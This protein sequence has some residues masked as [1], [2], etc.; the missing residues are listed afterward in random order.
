MTL[1]PQK[2]RK[3]PDEMESGSMNGA[4]RIA[5]LRLFSVCLNQFCE[6]ILTHLLASRVTGCFYWTF[7]SA[8]SMMNNMETN[9]IC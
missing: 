3:R 2:C 4:V 8:K 7:T 5:N 6:F 1:G 9:N